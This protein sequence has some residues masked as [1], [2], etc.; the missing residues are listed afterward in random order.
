MATTLSLSPIISKII[1]NFLHKINNI[2]CEGNKWEGAGMAIL[3]TQ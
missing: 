2:G 1:S 3:K